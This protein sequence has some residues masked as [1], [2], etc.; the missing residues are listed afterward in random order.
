[1]MRRRLVNWRMRWTAFSVASVPELV[2]RHRGRPNRCASV[3]V[4]GI[5]SDVGCAKWRPQRDALADRAHDGRVGVAH[6]H[7]AEAARACRRTRCRRRPRYASPGRGRSRSAKGLA[8]ASSTHA[9]RQRF[10]G[11]SQ[12]L[13]RT[14]HARDQRRLLLRNEAVERRVSFRGPGP[15]PSEGDGSG[16]SARYV[17]WAYLTSAEDPVQLLLIESMQLRQRR[18]LSGNSLPPIQIAPPW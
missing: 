5:R 1:M 9:A 18:F 13:A 8:A 6:H 3:R 14:Q 7:R 12:Q 16:P 10:L 15:P 4:T 11:Q 17:I 2:S